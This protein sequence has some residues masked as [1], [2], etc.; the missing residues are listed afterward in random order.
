[1]SPCPPG[2]QVID[3]Q[4]QMGDAGHRR[5]LLA[6]S[7]CPTVDAAPRA[8][9]TTQADKSPF[10]AALDIAPGD[11]PELPADR[12]QPRR[13]V[14]RAVVAPRRGAQHLRRAGRGDRPGADMDPITRARA[15]QFVELGE[16]G[17]GRRRRQSRPSAYVLFR[18]AL[19]EAASS[20]RYAAPVRPTGAGA[21]RTRPVD[22]QPERIAALRPS[23]RPQPRRAPDPLRR[24]GAGAGAAGAAAAARPCR[25]GERHPPGA[26][27]RSANSRRCKLVL[28]GATEGWTG[29]RPRSP[30]RACR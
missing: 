24:G 12:G 5:R 13:G 9:T 6:R 1:M 14:T 29:R 15:F 28:V 20:A 8:R 25:A 3:A 7:A 16:N 21:R 10:N 4:R 23:A 26:R 11:Q 19:R 2:A 27:A 30:P 22:A 18:N 17:R